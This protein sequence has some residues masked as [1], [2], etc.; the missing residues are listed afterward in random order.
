MNSLAK[1]LANQMPYHIGANEVT[2]VLRHEGYLLSMPKFYNMP[3]NKAIIE[4][5]LVYVY[6]EMIDRYVTYVTPK[7]IDF[8]SQMFASRPMGALPPEK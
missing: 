5:I 2:A 6:D 7:G 3:S 8:F 4:G 1:L